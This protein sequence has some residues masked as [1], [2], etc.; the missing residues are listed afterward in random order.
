M[1]LQDFAD[2]ADESYDDGPAITLGDLRGGESV[3]LTVEAEAET[4]SSDYADDDQDDAFRMDCTFGE[5]DH[6]TWEPDDHGPVEQGDQVTLVSWSRRLARAIVAA[7]PE[8]GETIEIHKS[9]TGKQADY[10]VEIHD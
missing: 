3:V 6:Y 2:E 10:S 7:D 9:G 5:C 1:S 4:F 8:I